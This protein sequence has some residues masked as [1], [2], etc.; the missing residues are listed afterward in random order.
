MIL[1]VYGSHQHRSVF[2]HII[3]TEVAVT[4]WYSNGLWASGQNIMNLRVSAVSTVL[5]GQPGCI[6]NEQRVEEQGLPVQE[7]YALGPI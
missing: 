5:E 4:A 7:M 3:K 6:H 1:Y 2:H